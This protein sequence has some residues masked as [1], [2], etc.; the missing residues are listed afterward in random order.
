A[1]GVEE[2][3]TAWIFS[4]AKDLNFFEGHTSISF[5]LL[6]TVHLIHRL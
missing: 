6:K 5:D 3:L 2:G 1:I 4:R